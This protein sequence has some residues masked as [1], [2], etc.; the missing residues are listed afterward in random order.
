M[1]N[2]YLIGLTGKLG[3]GKSTV[4]E[5]IKEWAQENGQEAQLQGFADSLKLSFARIFVPDATLDQ[6]L[7]FADSMKKNGALYFSTP[8][9]DHDLFDKFGPNRSITGRQ[10]LQHYGTEA[11]RRVFADNFWVDQLLPLNVTGVAG[12]YAWRQKWDDVDLMIVT[13]LRFPNEA[14]RI[15]DLEGMVFR[16]IR[17]ELDSQ[18]D[19]H[20]SEK[21][22]DDDYIYDTIV[23]DSSLNDL[24]ETVWAYMDHHFSGGKTTEL[25]KYGFAPGGSELAIGIGA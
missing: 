4:G 22:L 19:S 17:P 20:A 25:K 3:S 21:P 23:N 24:R 15:N 13:D 2:P 9:M 6:A 18:S 11:H 1:T 12:P 14:Q 5:Y 16:I 8:L 7:R 10:A